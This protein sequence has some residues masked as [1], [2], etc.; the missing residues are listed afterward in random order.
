MLRAKS[1]HQALDVGGTERM[2]AHLVDVLKKED[3]EV[4][5]TRCGVN[6]NAS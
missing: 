2:S 6:A 3:R 5:G 4:T 1:V